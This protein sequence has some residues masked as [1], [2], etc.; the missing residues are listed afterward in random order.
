MG[1]V[2]KPLCLEGDLLISYVNSGHML[3]CCFAEGNREVFAQFFTDDLK[4]DNNDTIDDILTS[5]TWVDFY[6]DIKH[7]PK[8]VASYNHCVY[9]CS[10]DDQPNPDPSAVR[11]GVGKYNSDYNPS[12][13]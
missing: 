13:K 5:D 11:L 7:N 12:L 3:P 6:Y 2:F 10:F 4:I 8:K 1:K 9:C